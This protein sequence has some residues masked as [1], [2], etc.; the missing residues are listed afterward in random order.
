MAA[1]AAHISFITRNYTAHLTA[2]V[3]DNG[4]LSAGIKAYTPQQG[5]VESYIPTVPTGWARALAAA[6]NGGKVSTAAAASSSKKPAAVAGA[7]EK[8]RDKPRH[9]LP[10]GAVLGKPFTQ[11]VSG[12]QL[13]HRKMRS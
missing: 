11:D 1:T 7:A 6:D 10:K 2:P 3:V 8:K 4:P 13:G 12:V 9:A 5:E